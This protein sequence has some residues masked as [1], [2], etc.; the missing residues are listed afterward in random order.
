MRF[1]QIL[2]SREIGGAG[3]IALGLAKFT[4]QQGQQTRVWIP[5]EGPALRSANTLGLQA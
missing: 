4:E 3:L 1:H 5:E 2:V